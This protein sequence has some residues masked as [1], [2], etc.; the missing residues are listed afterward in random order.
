MEWRPTFG[1]HNQMPVGYFVIFLDLSFVYLLRKAGGVYIYMYADQPVAD[2][3]PALLNCIACPS[4]VIQ[5]LLPNTCR[6]NIINHT[7]WKN[8]TGNDINTPLK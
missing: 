3:C 5:L 2:M 1:P 8:A 6:N 4:I 7:L